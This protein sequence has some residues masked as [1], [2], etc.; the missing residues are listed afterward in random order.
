[1]R[2]LFVVGLGFFGTV[3]AAADRQPLAPIP[4][5]QVPT[6]T[7]QLAGGSPA[8][9]TGVPTTAD[10]LVT[11]IDKKFKTHPLP[12]GFKCDL[13]ALN[14]K[15]ISDVFGGKAWAALGKV[16]VS[17]ALWKKTVQ[18]AVNGALKPPQPKNPAWYSPAV[19]L[20]AEIPN[21][22][23]TPDQYLLLMFFEEQSAEL[24]SNGHKISGPSAIYDKSP[25]RDILTNAG[26]SLTAQ[27]SSSN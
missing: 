14:P 27:S 6:S 26:I 22:T 18:P 1:M 7:A 20:R 10:Q 19:G 23:P 25:W 17:P 24:Y 8:T 21:G 2:A 16:E 4:L 3:A 15:Q 9:A 11:E 12:P 5:L 13:L